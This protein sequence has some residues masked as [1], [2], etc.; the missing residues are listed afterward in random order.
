MDADTELTEDEIR[1]VYARHGLT[2]YNSQL[3]ERGLG[4]FL[5]HVI[6]MQQLSWSKEE[7]NSLFSDISKKTLGY[8]LNELKKKTKLE[9][10]LETKLKEAVDKRN[11]LTHHFF[12]ENAYKFFS[13]KGQTE[14]IEELNSLRMQFEEAE[15]IALCLSQSIRNLI[16]V[17][18]KKIR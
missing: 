4:M 14:M 12:Y 5:F 16:G 1:E 17:D 10:D 18:E 11:Y 7:L 8:L 13:K 3:F 15:T 2:A 6:Q 9:P